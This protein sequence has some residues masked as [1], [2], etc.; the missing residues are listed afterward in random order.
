[1][2]ELIQRVR[3]IINMCW[4]SFSAKVGGGLIEINKEASMQLHFA[5]ILKNSIDLAVHHLDEFVTVELETGIP[6]NGRL[7]E[8]DIVIRMKK[9]SEV[10]FLPIEM[11]CYK[12]YA[13]S[14][15]KREAVD[16]FFCGVYEDLELLENYSQNT[17]YIEGIQLTMTDL[18]RIVHPNV[19]RGKYWAYDISDDAFIVNGI[20]LNI[21]IGGIDVN[22]TLNG[23]YQFN[24]VQVNNYYFLRL[25]N[26]G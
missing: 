23:S 18:R 14:G 1:M 22:I 13:S 8:C 24:W 25:E 3:G 26:N 6:I 7:R 11:K 4:N 10:S 15:G 2:E 19:R 17:N 5:Y 16:L 12:E 21:P 20:N 9:N